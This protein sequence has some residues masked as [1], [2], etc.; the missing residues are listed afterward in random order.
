[1]NSADFGSQMSQ[2]ASLY[3]IAKLSKNEPILIK[4][5]FDNTADSTNA[6]ITKEVTV[7][8]VGST[9]MLDTTTPELY[10]FTNYVR[11]VYANTGIST[12]ST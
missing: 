11:V 12:F 4:E 8:E 1:M 3:A 5:N 7:G 6:F 2:Y 10:K 9:A